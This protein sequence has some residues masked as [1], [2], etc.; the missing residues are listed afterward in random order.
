MVSRFYRMFLRSDG[1]GDFVVDEEFLENVVVQIDTIAEDFEARVM[2]TVVDFLESRNFFTARGA[3]R[4]P[5]FDEIRFSLDGLRIERLDVLSL[6]VGEERFE[7]EF[8]TGETGVTTFAA[9]RRD[10]LGER[11]ITR[12]FEG[13][14]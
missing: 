11:G 6:F 8:R 7:V 12:R 14:A 5:D 1:P 4:C 9:E 13:V 3:P 2:V 10:W